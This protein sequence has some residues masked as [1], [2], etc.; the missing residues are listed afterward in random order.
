MS[1]ILLYICTTIFFILSSTEGHSGW[2]YVSGIINGSIRNIGMHVSFW[3]IFLCRY[4]PR[5]G[6][7]G[8]YDWF[9][10]NLH[11]VLHSGCTN[12]NSHQ[13]CRRVP[14]SPHPLQHLL[15][16]DFLMTDILAGVRWY[17][18]AILICISLVISDVEYLLMCLLVICM[19]S[20]EKCQFRSSVH[21]LI[22]CLFW[23]CYGSCTLCKFW[24][25]IHYQLHHLEIFSL[26]LW[27]FF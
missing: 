27:I 16:V 21:L 9:L 5:S 7:A 1:N 22:V 4:I 11:T 15:F 10:R 19:S 13:Q 8:S 2:F 14:F 18:I 6:I 20:F 12:L 23:C 24:R 26:S 3:V 25:L 17:L